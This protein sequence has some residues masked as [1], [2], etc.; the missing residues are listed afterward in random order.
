VVATCKSKR[1]KEKKLKGV[2]KKDDI[3]LA[4]GKGGVDLKGKGKSA[5]QKQ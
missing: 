3:C 5:G 1:E 2:E 4:Q